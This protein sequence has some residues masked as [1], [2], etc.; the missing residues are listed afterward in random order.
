ME[1]SDVRVPDGREHACLVPH[2]GDVRRVHHLG[3]ERLDGDLSPPSDSRGRFSTRILG[4]SFPVPDLG[5]D[6]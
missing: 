2:L 6:L 1:E 3:V 5:N 4:Y